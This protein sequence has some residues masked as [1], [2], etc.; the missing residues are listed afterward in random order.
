MWVGLIQSVDD[1]KRKSL[2][3]SRGREFCPWAA[4]DSGCDIC[5]ISSSLGL[6]P[7]LQILDWPGTTVR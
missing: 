2:T 3:T 5:S 4:Q 7:A 6:Q 1:F